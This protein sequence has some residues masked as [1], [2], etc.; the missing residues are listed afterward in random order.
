MRKFAIRFTALLFF[1]FPFIASAQ[2]TGVVIGDDDNAPLRDVTV[3][4]KGTKTAMKTNQAGF[5]SSQGQ[6]R[7]CAGIHVCGLYPAGDHRGQ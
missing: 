7:R 5:Y 4:I 2:I 1:L 6:E 3:A